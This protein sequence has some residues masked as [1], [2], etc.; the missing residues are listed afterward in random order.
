MGNEETSMSELANVTFDES[1]FVTDPSQWSETL[2]AETARQLG[3]RE[4]GEAHLQVL[5]YMRERCLEHGSICAMEV[6][7]HGVHMDKDCVRRL[8]GGPVE[9]WKIAGLPNPGTEA[10]TYMENEE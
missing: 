9:A 8:F 4:L 7:C 10:L 1:G 5:R 6:I 3:I 2:A